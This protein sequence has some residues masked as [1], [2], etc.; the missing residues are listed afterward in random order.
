MNPEY[1]GVDNRNV[2]EEVPVA[3][4]PA[5]KKTNWAPWLA[6]GGIGVLVV[7]A[8]W[9]RDRELERLEELERKASK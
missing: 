4:P 5:K 9:S 6:V 1:F 7:Y 8:L 3:A 2:G